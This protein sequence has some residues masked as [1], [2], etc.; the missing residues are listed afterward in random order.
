MKKI[1]KTI[2]YLVIV[3]VVIAAIVWKLQ[4]NK[5]N[6]KAETELANAKA[7]SIPVKV[8]TV[9]VSN[10]STNINMTGAIKNENDLY[11]FAETQGR[12]TK[13]FK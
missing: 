7:T 13:I 4:A 5:A 6:N 9:N 2:L 11:L 3:A 12:I 10:Y 1:L 8:D